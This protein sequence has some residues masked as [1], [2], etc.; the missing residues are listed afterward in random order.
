MYIY[1]LDKIIQ[2]SSS[3]ILRQYVFTM[4]VSSKKEMEAK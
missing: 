2:Y 3:L 4:V 1:K